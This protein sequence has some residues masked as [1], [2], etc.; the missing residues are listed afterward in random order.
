MRLVFIA[1]FLLLSVIAFAQAP[2]AG[3]DLSNYGVRIEPDK[4]LIMVLA[5]LDAARTEN[6]KG[7]TV[8]V[9]NT[10]LPEQGT[11]F[12]ELLASDLAKM[13]EKLRQ[14]ISTFVLAHKRRNSSL[15][16]DELIAPFISMAYTLSPAPELS[17]PVVTSDL[18][19]NLLDVLDFAPLVRDVYRTTNIGAN[20]NDYVKKYQEAADA[21]LRPSA[22][23]M[24]N[25]LLTYLH[26]RPQ[27]A[28]YERVK[29]ETGKAGSKRGT[30]QKTEVRERERR[31]IIVP[32]LLAP[33][34]YV[35]F[36]NIKD[37]YF[38]VIPA[39]TDLANSEVRRAFLQ[40]V[41]D[42]LV[43]AT[44]KDIE[45]VRPGIKQLLD[46]RRKVEPKTSPDVYVT[47]TRSLIA[48]IDAKQLENLK[49]R[50]AT[51]TARSKIAAMGGTDPTKKLAQELEKARQENADETIFRI[52][53]DYEKGAVL[54]FYFA[55]QLVG[56]ESS[57]T[58]IAASMR[59]MIRSLDASK[60]AGRYASYAEARKRA[61]AAREER[62]KNP[63]S[64]AIVENPVTTKLLAI[65]ETI[66]AKNYKQAEADLKQLLE[67]NPSEP[68]VFFNVGRVASLSA[69]T[70]TDPADA[71]KQSAK[72]LEAKVAYENVIRIAAVQ[73][74][75]PALVSLSY[76]ALG[77]IH[78]FYDQKGNAIGLY[79]AAIKLGD[80]AGGG[81][82]EAMAAKQRLLKDQ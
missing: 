35:N 34:G 26:T 80:V 42:P 65:Q 70:L 81:H 10:S 50:I 24:V 46:E 18:P 28:A 2:G 57:E 37:D 5:T 61:A 59:E 23:F 4:R 67:Q 53:E 77:R 56:I 48:A 3:F 33:T 39:D 20:L 76:V 68:R 55:D 14:R 64:S 21:R 78:E 16:D 43:L 29:T 63:Q 44:A 54:G 75:D 79:D 7:E 8:R 60:E 25:D 19:G 71:D 72:L 41:I 17:D 38:V 74:I 32:E 22:R 36:V 11:K 51:E 12:R 30:I 27:L 1:L 13:D 15:S 69:G 6:E 31:F 82:K 40:F 62:R 73:K 66:K 9:I 45:T 49:N 52:S 47:I 58:D